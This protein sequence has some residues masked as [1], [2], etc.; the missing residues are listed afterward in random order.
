MVT[1]TLEAIAGSMLNFFNVIGTNIPNK[2]ATI[3]FKTI[4]TDIIIESWISS[5]HICTINALMIANITPFNTPIENSFKIF[6][7]KLFFVNSFVA[8]VLTVTAKLFLLVWPITITQELP[9]KLSALPVS[10]ST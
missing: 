5:N 7:V 1:K 3:I 6:W 8:I 9:P 10:S 4:E 2:P